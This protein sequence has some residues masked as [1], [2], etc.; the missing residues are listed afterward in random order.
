MLMTDLHNIIIKYVELL[1]L[2]KTS[3]ASHWTIEFIQ[4]CKDWCILVEV[5]LSTLDTQDREQCLN[6]VRNQLETNVPTLDELLDAQHY[7]YK[8]LLESKYLN[9]QVYYYVLSHYE[10]LSCSE[11]DVLQKVKKHPVYN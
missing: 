3:E 9:N 10:F 2:S 7:F 11:K 5:E 1:K 8:T 6:S 4:Q